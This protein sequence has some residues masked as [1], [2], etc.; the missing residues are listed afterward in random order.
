MPNQ[1]IE[2]LR[3]SARLIAMTLDNYRGFATGA[4]KRGMT[5]NQARKP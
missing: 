3:D 2:P 5:L 1:A 4:G